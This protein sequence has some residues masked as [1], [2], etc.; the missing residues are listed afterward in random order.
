MDWLRSA[1]AKRPG[2]AAIVVGATVVTYGELDA[3]ADGVAGM[4]AASGLANAPV[5]LAGDR[6]PETIAALWG[7]Q[8]AG[9]VPALIEP[10][11]PVEQQRRAARSAGVRGLWTPPDGG[12]EQLA[13]RRPPREGRDALPGGE[14]TVVV[15][16]SGTRGTPTPVTLT[17]NNVAASV[18]GSKDRLGN[19]A[20][21][22]WL[23]VLPFTHV[24]G[25]SV[26]WRQAERG[27]PVVLAASVTEASSV[28]FASVVPTMLRR[29]MS[30]GTLRGVRA[31]VGGGPVSTGLLR[32]AIGSGI[33]ALQT[34][35]M[36]ETASQVCTVHPDR[37]EDELGT[38]GTAIRGAEIRI[39]SDGRIAVR[40]EMVAAGLGDARGWFVTNDLGEMD[41]GGRL[42]V[43]GRA[44]AVILTG[45]ENVHP[46]RVQAVL[47][48]H[49]AVAAA[50]VFGEH[51]DEWGSRVIAEV[52]ADGVEPEDLRAWAAGF[53][54]PAEIPKEIR[55]VESLP[56]KLG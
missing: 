54:H 20:D 42:V 48:G 31:L 34:Y 51:D 41:P 33:V 15:F 43:R 16:T 1:A 2:S 14:A 13:S 29:A 52:L 27:A 38:A 32:E 9:A 39:E 7:I 18:A 22:R 4:V 45:G 26:L 12:L 30:A 40:G 50:R 25:L 28:T 10:R 6:S 53:L 8:R 37:L 11:W 56:T 23:G 36:T 19:E 49:P 3:A 21:D 46:E 47:E 55:I 24:G 17:G 35:G 44:D 5:G